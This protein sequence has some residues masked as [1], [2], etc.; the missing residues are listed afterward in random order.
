M[1]FSE[2]SVK[3]LGVTID[4]KLNF[5]EHVT[6]ICKKA[7]RQLN[8]LARI[9]RY[10]NPNSRI[11]LYNS[12]V[13]SNLNYCPNVWH[14]CG[15][16]NNEK[17]EK[18]QERALRILYRDYASSYDELITQS[19]TE[20]ILTTRL[21]K[22]LIDIFKTLRGM[23]PPYLQQMYVLKETQYDFR[24]EKII[25]QPETNKVTYGIRS[26]SYV[27]AKLW[28]DMKFKFDSFD[29][30]EIHDFKRLLNNW[31]GPDLNLFDHYV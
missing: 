17:L 26:L 8:A 13:M 21:K 11:I 27:G 16:G 2:S 29:E 4:S 10:L 7:A 20:K 9:S 22:I 24:N 6:I 15:K 25:I 28:N 14:F 19:C 12:F 23:N 31:N 3:T 1:L 30:M 18:I 5:S